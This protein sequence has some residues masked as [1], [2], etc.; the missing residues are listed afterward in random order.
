[1]VGIQITTDTLENAFLTSLLVGEG[2]VDVTFS[3]PTGAYLSSADEENISSLVPDAV[4]IMPVLV[5]RGPALVSPQFEPSVKMAGIPLNFSSV[6]G[7]FVEWQ[8]EETIDISDYLTDNTSVLI[9]S[10]L[11][12]D[13]ELNESTE[14]PLILETSFKNSTWVPLIN[15]ATGMPVF[16]MTTGE[17]INTTLFTERRV[18]LT[19]KGVYDSRIPG[20][21]ASYRGLIFSLEGFQDWISISDP[22]K[23]IDILVSTSVIEVGIDIHFCQPGL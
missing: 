4:G 21:G 7:S 9:S 22:D 14:F 8:T 6:F 5:G 3:S 18:E 11:A 20:I 23:E 12:E 13:L 19:V 17:M 10:H 2:E 1:M 15:P 16:N